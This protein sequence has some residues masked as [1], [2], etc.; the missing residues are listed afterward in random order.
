MKGRG[1]KGL[2]PFGNIIWVR[3][4]F[5]FLEALTEFRI[6]FSQEG[7]LKFLIAF[8]VFIVSIKESLVLS[9]RDLDSSV[10][11]ACINKFD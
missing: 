9:L 8:G 10:L 11:I 3:R 2:S 5:K 4:I 1:T 6:S 7:N